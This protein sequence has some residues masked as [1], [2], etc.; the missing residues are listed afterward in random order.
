M[1]NL[2]ENVTTKIEKLQIPYML[3]GSMAMGFYAIQRTTQDIDLVI[4]LFKDDIPKIIT[5]FADFYYHKISME[6]AVS[7]NSMFNLID[8]K[9]GLKI[10]FI[11]RKNTE[12]DLLAFQRKQYLPLELGKNLYFWVITVEDLIIAKIRWIQVLQSEK[13]LRDIENLLFNPNI[14]KNYLIKWI[15]KLELNTFSIDFKI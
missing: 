10:D 8:Q 7:D 1:I 11:L 15:N 9:S 2:L 13:Q 5:A 12:Y 4:E 14:D 3:S 6:E